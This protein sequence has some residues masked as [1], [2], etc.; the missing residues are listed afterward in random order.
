MALSG[1]TGKV[2]AEQTHGSE[3]KES[4]TWYILTKSYP[5][6]TPRDHGNKL[7][8]GDNVDLDKLIVQVTSRVIIF[9]ELKKF[10]GSSEGKLNRSRS[11]TLIFA[12]TSHSSWRRRVVVDS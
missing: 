2:T 12:D 4:Y 10:R 11:K 6:C 8:R 9:N 5:A 1:G 7:L 3:L